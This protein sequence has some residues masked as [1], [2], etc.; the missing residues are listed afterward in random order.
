[1]E[2]VYDE[3]YRKA[4]KLD[5]EDFAITFDP[6]R[7]C[8]ADVIRNELLVENP[9]KVENHDGREGSAADSMPII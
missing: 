6:S 2:D 4:G 5:R 8:L 9:H 1:M 7:S 3:T